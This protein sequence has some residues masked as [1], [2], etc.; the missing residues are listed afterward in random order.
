[1]ADLSTNYMGFNL[2]NPVIAASSGLTNSVE[3]VME[4][5]KMGASAVVLKSL[6]EEQISFF[7][8]KSVS[9]SESIYSYPEANDYISNYTKDKSVS[10][11]L[12]LIRDCKQKVSIPVI[13]SINCVSSS[14]WTSFA[15]R[16]GDRKSTRLNSSHY[17]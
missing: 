5:E 1:M 14:E 2:K 6:F 12:E 16:I 11:Y 10:E 17:S 4:L 7:I 3:K 15:R 13:A 9:Q 8:N